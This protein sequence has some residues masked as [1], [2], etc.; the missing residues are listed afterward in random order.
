MRDLELGTI[1][2]ISISTDGQWGNTTFGYGSFTGVVS[3]D[4]RF[5]AFLSE[6]TN[7][8]PGV[9]VNEFN[10][11]VRDVVAQ[12][13]ERV[14]V[15]SS[16][17]PAPGGGNAQL[18][19]PA[20]S[21]DGRYVV[22]TSP[23]PSL[24][25]NDRNGYGDDVYLHDR[26]TGETALVDRSSNGTQGNLASFEGTIS[27][28]GRFVAFTS[29]STNLVPND[30]NGTNDIF[31]RDL[32]A[33]T[34]PLQPTCGGL[35]PTIV[36]TPGRDILTGTPGRDVIVGMDGD[37]TIDGL[38]G[39]DVICGGRG[40]DQVRAGPGDDLVLGGPGADWLGG[41]D[42]NDRLVGRWGG[43]ALNGG[44]GDDTLLGRGG[45]DSLEG[46]GGIDAC[47]GGSGF[48]FGS[49]CETLVSV[50]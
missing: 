30:V 32:K 33:T 40:A 8:V 5:V 36:G 11:F 42:G 23:S 47:Y 9:T 31:V 15:T 3:A 4:G 17:D 1:T 28:D 6:A 16:G 18:D 39:D 14:N 49:A 50:P 22:F 34:P 19:A 25:P 24:V 26:Q 10:V 35:R 27:G 12:T 48:D 37:D 46:G 43:D 20:I 45:S 41:G 13:T 38:G 29:Q 21:D 2:P 44:P 7:L